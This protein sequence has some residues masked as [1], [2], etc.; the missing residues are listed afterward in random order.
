MEDLFTALRSASGAAAAL[1]SGDLPERGGVPVF[2][3]SVAHSAR[4]PI[5]NPS[6]PRRT[7]NFY[8]LVPTVG[9]E[10]FEPGTPLGPGIWAVAWTCPLYPAAAGGA[11]HGAVHVGG[12]VS[13]TGG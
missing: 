9:G 4:A 10:P 5:H 12:T 8:E 7:V 2:R 6:Q 11:A 3:C 13:A 1:A